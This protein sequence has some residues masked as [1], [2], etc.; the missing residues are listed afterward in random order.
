VTRA[1]ATALA[2]LLLL[3]AAASAHATLDATTPERGARLDAAPEQVTL[4]FS[5]GVEANFGAVRVYDNDGR[6]VQEG[7]A[8]HPGDRG[9]EVAVRL[10]PGLG[11]GGYT[12]TYR[13]ISADSH[14]VSGGFVFVVGDAAAPSTTVG[15]L[16][17]DDDAAGPVTGVAFGGARAVQ[18]ASIALGL[19]TLIF[20]LYC[21]L[22]GLRAVAGGAEEWSEASAAFGR[23]ARGLLLASALAG[24]LSAAAA[25]V[26]QGAVAGGTSFWEAADPEVIGEVLGTRFGVFWGLAIVAWAITAVLAAP[27]R[28][29]PVLEPAA[30]GATGLALPGGSRLIVLAVPLG[31]LAALPAL[32]G[33]ASVQPPVA[34]LFPANV[35]HVLAMAAWLGGVAVLVLALR[36]ATVRLEQS[37]RTRLLASVV[38][39]FSAMAGLA[40]AVLLASG[41][42][43]SVVEIRTFPN[44][45][46][47]AFGRAVLIKLVLFVGLVGLGWTNRNRLLPALRAAAR[48]GSSPGR[49]G[50]LL[51]RTLRAELAIG[52]AALAVTG[53]LAG[54]APSIAETSGPFS[55]NA[56]IGPARLEVTV[57]PARTGPNEMHLYLFDRADGS[58]WDETEELNVAAELPGKDIPPVAMDATKAGPG[59]YVVSGAAFGVAGDWTVD[60]RARVSDF[61]EYTTEIIVPIE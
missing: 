55:T 28:V 34:V 43:Q 12:V 35:L 40:V 51:R 54:Y 25:I 5:E 48:D 32:G 52:V 26:L 17:G 1:L 2:I 60:V 41:I 61:D 22:P 18:Y 50:L 29:M 37:D 15:E 8:F 56:D 38:A 33:H 36:P 7:N 20:A 58:Q 14:P 23:R 9:R 16:L 30:V 6:E 24:I 21:W 53:A 11:D 39:R 49:A 47:S 46:D 42:V 13:V 27:P 3:P 59:H 57:D 4:T 44:L 31:L 45:V 19:G 10:K